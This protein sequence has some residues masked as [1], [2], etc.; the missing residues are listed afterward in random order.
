MFWGNITKRGREN[1]KQKNTFGK[2]RNVP[3]LSTLP[4][5]PI[6]SPSFGSTSVAVFT[7]PLPVVSMISMIFGFPSV[8]T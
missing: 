1:N 2:K 6:I 4:E 7:S 5:R 8:V 3:T